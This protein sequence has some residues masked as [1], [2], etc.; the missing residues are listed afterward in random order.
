MWLLPEKIC[1]S[2]LWHH[3]YA[4]LRQGV[5]EI[6]A[7]CAKQIALTLVAEW[8]FV[9]HTKGIESAEWHKGRDFAME[10]LGST[11]EDLD[12]LLARVGE[13]SEIF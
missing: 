7:S 2:V 5:A 6:P 3:D 4:A 8:I 13:E 10:I 9:H 1:Q 11:Q 12:G